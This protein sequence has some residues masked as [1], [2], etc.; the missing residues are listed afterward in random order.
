MKSPAR[1]AS[2]ASEPIMAQ[3][4]SAVIPT[5]DLFHKR[6]CGV[7]GSVRQIS[8]G[9]TGHRHS[10]SAAAGTPGRGARVERRGDFASAAEDRQPLTPSCGATSPGSSRRRTFLVRVFTRTRARAG[11]SSCGSAPSAAQEQPD[12]PAA[13]RLDQRHRKTARLHP[14]LKAG[15]DGACGEPPGGSS[16]DDDDRLDG[17]HDIRTWLARRAK[18]SVRSR[19]GSGSDSGTV[20]TYDRSS[21]T[22]YWR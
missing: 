2:T 20:H 10:V 9:H 5:F 13:Q 19:S 21:S 14:S 11:R 7:E 4:D 18:A 22:G 3:N 17:L 1:P 16:A 8:G 15:G 12:P 6:G